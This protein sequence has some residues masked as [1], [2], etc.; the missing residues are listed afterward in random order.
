MGESLPF[1]P[2]QQQNSKNFQIRKVNNGYIVSVYDMGE[3]V[4]IFLTLEVALN[5]IREHVG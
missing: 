3:H 1:L 5:F 2:S 4:F